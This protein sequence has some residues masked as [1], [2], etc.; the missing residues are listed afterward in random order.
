MPVTLF[1]WPRTEAHTFLWYNTMMFVGTSLSAFFWR[2]W[3][4]FVTA[5]VWCL[6]FAWDLYIHPALF[7]EEN[8]SEQEKAAVKFEQQMARGAQQDHH[9]QRKINERLAEMETKHERLKDKYSEAKDKLQEY[10]ELQRE[11]ARLKQG[12]DESD[13]EV[14]ANDVRQHKTSGR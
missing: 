10:E 2:R 11:V 6:F 7:P 1:D 4:G 5:T 14:T 8:L 3:V 9:R 12:D 13:A